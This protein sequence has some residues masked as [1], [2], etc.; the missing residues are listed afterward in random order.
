MLVARARRWRL[1]GGETRFKRAYQRHRPVPC[2]GRGT[3]LA[4]PTART[5]ERNLDSVHRLALLLALS[6]T[7]ALGGAAAPAQAQARA[8]LGVTPWI[9]LELDASAAHRTNPP[10]ASRALAHLSAAIY[11]AAL[12]AVRTRRTPL[13]A[14]P[15]PC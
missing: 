3:L 15:R 13:P 5:P 11:L 4:C 12:P 1:P 9:E 10:R 8:P 7:L 2:C 6:L 14:R